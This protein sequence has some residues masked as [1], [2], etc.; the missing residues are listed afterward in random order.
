LNSMI[1]SIIRRCNYSSQSSDYYLLF[2]ILLYTTIQLTSS[3]SMSGQQQHLIRRN[4]LSIRVVSYNVLSSELARPSYYTSYDP[5]HLDK[6]NR[7][8]K[9]LKKLN[10]E[11][12]HNNQ[13][14]NDTSQNQSSQNPKRQT[15]ICL[16]EVS[17]EWAGHFHTFFAN[18]RYHF[19]TGMY[20]TKFNGYMGVGIAYPIDH[21]ETVQVD[22]CRLS[23]HR[24]GG[25][26]R[27]PSQQTDAET[28]TESESTSSLLQSRVV[29]VAT[30]LTTSI[31]NLARK[32]QS[33]IRKSKNFMWTHI[34][35]MKHHTSEIIEP[36]DKSEYRHNMMVSICLKPKHDNLVKSSKEDATYTDTVTDA[37]T[38]SL[39]TS[40]TTPFWVSTYHMP[41]IFYVPA[42]MTIHAEMA[43]KHIQTL[44][45]L[46][47]F[48]SSSSS[49]QG[50]DDH[51]HENN[52]DNIPTNP[53]ILCGDFNIQPN[54]PQ[55]HLLTTG[56]LDVPTND[57]NY[58]PIKHGMEW[59]STIQPMYS[60][61]AHH[62]RH[63][64]PK[65]Q[66]KEP[67]YTNYAQVKDED[68]FI[69]T[70]DYIFLSQSHPWKVL[71]VQ[72]PSSSNDEDVV[73][74]NTNEEEKNKQE[75]VGK[76]GPFPNSI[77]P[78]DHLLISADLDLVFDSSISPMGTIP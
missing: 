72:P 18:H 65:L 3:L 51:D 43:A 19:V 75:T 77:E 45:S 36:W 34:P 78:S 26:P 1:I 38:E 9:V 2:I 48:N 68:P 32:V 27:P 41:C 13:S 31:G 17:N 71:H 52:N 49:R 29:T 6:H 35:F 22:M 28:E 55:Y 37:D 5:S 57:T 53:Y 8:S 10:D 24:I 40:S 59:K 20:G 70:L 15:I 60:A 58:P 76:E 62:Y 69:G 64:H 12:I 25:W 66:H 67:N 54:S 46:K 42:V 30:T 11:I 61:Y 39:S 74:E 47:S 56:K 23:D 50:H 4:P 33:K 63:H 21:F 44:A 14:N 16:Q 7:L 73:N